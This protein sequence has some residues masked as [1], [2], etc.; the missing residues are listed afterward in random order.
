MANFQLAARI[1]KLL[2]SPPT[3]NQAEVNVNKSHSRALL[4]VHRGFYVI[5]FDGG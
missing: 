2:E 3:R 5:S 1:R 4:L